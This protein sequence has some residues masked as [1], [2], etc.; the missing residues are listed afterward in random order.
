ME[1][2]ERWELVAAVI[3][4]QQKHNAMIKIILKDFKM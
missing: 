4:R 1:R 3:K 2:Q